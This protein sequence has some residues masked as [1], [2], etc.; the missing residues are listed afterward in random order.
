MSEQ[1]QTPLQRWLAEQEMTVTALADLFGWRYNYVADMVRGTRPVSPAF[2][3]RFAEVFG[4]NEAQALF[5][6]HPEEVQ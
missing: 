6:Q 1:T 5:A 3:W 2:Q 4:F